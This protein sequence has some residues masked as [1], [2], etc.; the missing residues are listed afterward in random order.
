MSL[1]KNLRRRYDV[2]LD[3]VIEGVKEYLKRPDSSPAELM[4]Y[5]E[6]CK[7]EKLVY[8]YLQALVAS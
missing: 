3:V 4:E 5:A 7:A 2:G 1:F 6:I 8:P